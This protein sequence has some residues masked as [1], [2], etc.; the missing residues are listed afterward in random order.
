[1]GACCVD[2]LMYQSSIFVVRARKH[3]TMVDSDH[4]FNIV[5]NL[6]DCDFNADVSNQ[7]WTGDIIYI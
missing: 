7:K 6:L 2:C 4:K 5:S 1:M 3:K